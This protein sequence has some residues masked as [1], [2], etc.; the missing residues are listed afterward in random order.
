MGNSA[1]DNQSFGQ[2]ARP[3]PDKKPAAMTTAPTRV[4][5]TWGPNGV[6]ASW[7]EIPAPAAPAAAAPKPNLPSGRDALAH[8][9]A[10]SA[11]DNGRYMPTNNP[12]GMWGGSSAWMNG[13]R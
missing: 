13:G 7:K 6:V 3:A 9:I 10:L 4:P 8:M 11:S 5:A 1:R 2:G 12:N